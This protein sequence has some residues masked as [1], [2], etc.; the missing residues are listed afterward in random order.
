[1][2]EIP[3]LVSNTINMHSTMDE[4]EDLIYLLHIV[5]IVSLI[6]RV[7]SELLKPK[8]IFLLFGWIF[9]FQFIVKMGPNIF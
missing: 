6:F 8:R 4:A 3:K 2:D 5:K 1:M 7:Q 9:F